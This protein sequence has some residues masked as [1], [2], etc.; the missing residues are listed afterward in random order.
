MSAFT[1]SQSELLYAFSGSS[2][3]LATFTA[4]DNLL[5]TYPLIKMPDMAQLFGSTGPR[6]SALK[7]RA[8]GKASAASATTLTYTFTVRLIN[9][10]TFSST[11]SGQTNLVVATSSAA[12]TVSGVTNGIWQID[13]D[14]VLRTLHTAGT[15][16]F[17]ITAGGLIAGSAFSSASNSLPAAGTAPTATLDVTQQYYLFLSAACGTSSASNTIDCEMIKLYGEN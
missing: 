8:L 14:M 13:M 17:T 5:K 16:T 11:T 3:P 10:T 9:T 2:T 15:P 7:L 12:A 4:E 6:S 1:Q